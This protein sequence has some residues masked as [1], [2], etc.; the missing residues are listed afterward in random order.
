VGKK[1]Y[2]LKTYHLKR[3]ITFVEKGGVLDSHK[4]IPETV[5]EELYIEEQ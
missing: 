5:R 2:Q 1:H 3:L 4:D